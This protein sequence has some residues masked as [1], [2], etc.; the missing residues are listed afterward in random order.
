MLIDKI[1][2]ADI[3]E[4]METGNPDN[5]PEEIVEYLELL[6]KVYGMTLRIDKFGSKEMVV[7]HLMVAEKLGGVSLS[8]YKASQIYNEAIE[9]FYNDKA[10]SKTAWRNFYASIMDKAINF[11]QLTQKDPGDAK[12]IV[13]M[14]KVAAE[15]RGAFDDEIEE[16]PEE[17]MRTP[18]IIYSCDAEFLGL[19]KV[20]R[21][22]LSAQ[23]DGYKELSEKEKIHIKREAQILPIKI[24][25]NEQEDARKS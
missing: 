16:I 18:F 15:T 20:D 4:F 12:K 8:K 22:A 7:R 2:L 14:A 23:I 21:N 10:V 17:L 25:P 3:Y 1:E 13:D 6:N 24:F 5:A 19:P 11:A 9:Y